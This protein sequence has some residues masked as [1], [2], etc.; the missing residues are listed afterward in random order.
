VSDLNR[1]LKT[2]SFGWIRF[3]LDP[4]PTAGYDTSPC[5]FVILLRLPLLPKQNNKPRALVRSHGRGQSRSLSSGSKSNTPPF[6]HESG[7][8]FAEHEMMKGRGWTKAE[9]PACF[10]AGKASRLCP[11]VLHNLAYS[12]T[13]HNLNRSF[14]TLGKVRW[15]FVSAVGLT[16]SKTS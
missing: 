4:G 5:K 14:F 8:T 3:V 13:C 7:P 10:R 11:P 15:L 12:H 9:D 16:I 1:L 2:W 6:R